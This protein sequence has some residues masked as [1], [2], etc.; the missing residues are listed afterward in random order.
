MEHPLCLKQCLTSHS[1]WLLLQGLTL[2]TPE[3]VPFRLT[4]NL[5][6]GFGITGVEGVFRRSAEAA[7]A[8]L[9]DN[10]AALV[11][12]QHMC[13]MLTCMCNLQLSPACGRGPALHCAMAR[14]SPAAASMPTDMAPTTHASPLPL[15]AHALHMPQSI[16]R[17]T[18]PHP[19]SSLRPAQCL[20]GEHD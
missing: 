9:R 8:V 19:R 6:D 3:L 1:R 10:R 14:L 7:L 16:P 12:Q 18:H 11:S 5:L 20:A 15:A 2:A 17:L 13:S 4:Q